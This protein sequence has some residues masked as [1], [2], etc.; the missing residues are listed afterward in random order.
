VT[1]WPLRT[2]LGVL[3]VA[4]L[5]TAFVTNALVGSLEEF[6]RQAGLSEFLVA[7]V[8]VAIVGNAAEH[9]SAVLVARHG[10]IRLATEIALVSSAQ[11][12]SLLIPLV[13]LASW[14][15]DPLTFSFRPI[16]LGA[17]AFATALTAVVLLPGRTSRL[18]GVI[19]LCAYAGLVVAFAYAGNR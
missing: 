16:E 2:A 3:A 7:I 6:A 15:I 17:L 18:G 11:V 12:A 1:G 8:I 10:Q 4:T 5:V 19:L 14:T 9:G 13:A